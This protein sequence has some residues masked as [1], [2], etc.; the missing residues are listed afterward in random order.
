M[1]R[2][3]K[4]LIQCLSIGLASYIGVAEAAENAVLFKIH[5]IVP[6]KDNN[7]NVV[8]CDLGA[9]F[10]NRT[11]TEVSNAAINL[12]WQDEVVSDAIDEE[13]RANQ[14]SLR[15]SR[16]NLSR[17]NTAT[18]SDKNVMLN[19]K[20]PP[21]KPYQQVTLKSKVNTDRCFLLL[22]DMEVEVLNCNNGGT[23]AGIGSNA[24]CDNLFRFVSVKNPEYYTEF[25]VISPEEQKQQEM[26]KFE[27]EK[28]EIDSAYNAAMDSI[29]QL[30]VSFSEAPRNNE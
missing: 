5:D 23:A 11:A 2:A 7:G 13:D 25:Q 24:S 17:Y 9:T 21:L 3:N 19:L 28:R 16:R 20:L 4:L 30:I 10:Y 27:E 6:V 18:Y 1:K 12:V 14:E 29:N 26:T 22:N 8:S 15:L